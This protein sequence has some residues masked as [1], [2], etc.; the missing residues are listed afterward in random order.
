[1]FWFK[2]KKTE[3]EEKL[4]EKNSEEVSKAL[5]VR[6]THNIEEET[7]PKQKIAAI[8]AAIT[9]Y[10][11]IER[12]QAYLQ[13]QQ[14][15]YKPQLNNWRKQAFYDSMNIRQ[16]WQ[17]RA[18]AQAGSPVSRRAYPLLKYHFH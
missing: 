13:N 15:N 2:K 5:E 1:M 12:E 6:T 14:I 10:I 3:I 18:G 17:Q 4:E 11:N 16:L 9:T 8:M 7:F